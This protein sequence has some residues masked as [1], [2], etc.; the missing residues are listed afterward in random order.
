MFDTNLQ[1][2]FTLQSTDILVD[3]KLIQM[4]K[5]FNLALEA[6]MFGNVRLD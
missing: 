3:I 2:S 5:I 6:V 4:Y 1:N